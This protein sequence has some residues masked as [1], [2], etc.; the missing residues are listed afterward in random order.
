TLLINA[1]RQHQLPH[2]LIERMVQIEKRLDSTFNNFRARLAGEPT[3][4][5]RLREV[6]RE[7]RDVA[8]RR[9]AWEASKQIGA[10]VERELLEL[11]GLRNQG[12]HA[13]GFANYYSMRLELD[14]LNE[15]EL[16][17]TLA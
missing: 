16:F 4:D 15:A 10:E 12:A 3:A 7:S 8:E 9:A 13:L 1:Q 6:L 11:V 17:A 14:E 5:N 2:A